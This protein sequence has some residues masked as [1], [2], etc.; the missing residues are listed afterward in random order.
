VLLASLLINIFGLA[1]PFF[2]MNVYDRVIPN[3][4]FDTLWVLAVGIGVIYLFNLLMRGLRGY[5]IDEAGK[6]ANLQLSAALLEKVLGLRLEVRPKSV[7]AFSKN[8]QQF[9]SVRDFITSFSITGPHR[10]ALHG[11]WFG[12]HLVSGRTAGLHPSQRRGAHGPVRPPH[13]SPAQ[14]RCGEKLSG[15]GP[16]ELHPG[17]GALR[18]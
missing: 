15:L 17:G 13:P 1:G 6:K 9:E 4:A 3:L 16:E 10:P 11:A 8:L 18:H 14:T 2:T 5:F 12:R 7:G